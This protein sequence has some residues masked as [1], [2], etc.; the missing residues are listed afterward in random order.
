MN[1]AVIRT[2]VFGIL[3]VALLVL[4]GVTLV[5]KNFDFV[6]T[7]AMRGLADER[8]RKLE[9]EKEI[10]ETEYEARRG[11]PTVT[12]KI[13]QLPDLRH[14]TEGAIIKMKAPHFDPIAEGETK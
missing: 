6:E 8:I 7:G 4:L 2:F 9:R 11:L 14:P 12:E 1:P 3:G 13:R 10:L 5:R